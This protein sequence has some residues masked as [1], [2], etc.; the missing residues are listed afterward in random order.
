MRKYI[1]SLTWI[2]LFLL[3]TSCGMQKKSLVADVM[4]FN[5]RLDVS[6]DSLNSWQHRKDNVAGMIRYY[7]PDIIGMQEVLHSQLV[8]LTERL[9]RYTDVGVGRADGKMAGEYCSLFFKTDHFELLKEGNFSLSETP[10]KFGVK[11]WDAAYERMATWA[12]LKDKATGQKFICVNTHLDNEGKLARKEGLKLVLVKA[13][14]LGGGLPVIVMGD[15]NDTAE[16][17]SIRIMDR[18]GMKN[19]RGTAAVVYG[20]SWSF[21]DFGRLNMAERPL[22]DHIYV[23]AP[24]EVNKYRVVNDTPEYGY[25]SDHNP[26]LVNITIKK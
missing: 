24:I 5:I 9:P 10:L 4:T 13:K 16:S 12:V 20:P 11:G 23:S 8:D 22:I 15:F 6:S 17:E 18:N 19:T 2:L 14:E 1:F 21:H 25:L 3:T 26:V 7:E